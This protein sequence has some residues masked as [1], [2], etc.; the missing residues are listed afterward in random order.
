MNISTFF[1][2]TGP[3]LATFGA[4]LLAYDA[5]QAPMQIH[6]QRRFDVR[7]NSLLRLHQYLSTTYPS[8]PYTADEVAIAQAQRDEALEKLK[9]ELNTNELDYKRRVSDFALWGFI[10]VAVG[11]VAQ[12]ASAWMAS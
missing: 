8:P 4:A 12:A 9:S 1:A 11:S 3:L 6:L 7:M 2:I 10:F 5:F